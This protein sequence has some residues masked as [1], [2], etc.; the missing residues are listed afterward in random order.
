[1][2]ILAHLAHEEEHVNGITKSVFQKYLF[3]THPELSEKLFTYLHHNAQ[4][5]TTYISTTAFKQQA[6]KFLSVMNDQAILENYIKMYSNI[7]DGGNV[8]P[9]TLKALLICCYQLAMENNSTSMCL[10]SEQIINA[11]VVSCVSKFI[12]FNKIYVVKIPLLCM[13]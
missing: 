4:A 8:T 1:M 5:T 13:I 7:K 9:E 3:P 10:R 6:E 2:Q 11:V 12:Q